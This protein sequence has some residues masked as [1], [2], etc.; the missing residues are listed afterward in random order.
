MVAYKTDGGPRQRESLPPRAYAVLKEQKDLLEKTLND[1]SSLSQQHL[2]SVLR[3]LQAGTSALMVTE[4]AIMTDA[5]H[6][7]SVEYDDSY[8]DE[9][10]D[11]TDYDP[12]P[13]ASV[14][15]EPPSSLSSE[16]LHILQAL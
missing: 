4:E 8:N 5:T 1:S 3:K 15:M 11:A 12:S 9:Y 16:A 6:E 13:G 10:D 7:S 2:L 14:L